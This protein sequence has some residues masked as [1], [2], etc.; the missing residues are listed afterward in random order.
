MLCLVQSIIKTQDIRVLFVN[1]AD[2]DICLSIECSTTIHIYK[3]T[4]PSNKHL[5]THTHARTHDARTDARTHSRT[6]ARTHT[7]THTT[8]TTTTLLSH[9]P[10]NS[11]SQALSLTES[12][13]HA[14]TKEQLAR[15][16]L[17]GYKNRECRGQCVLAELL[18]S[19][20]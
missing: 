12:L 5:D 10:T 1:I 19:K 8:T 4:R 9:S 3:L 16:E 17:G 18:W 2:T 7:H 20:R 6:H 14:L 11:T 13:P 15:A